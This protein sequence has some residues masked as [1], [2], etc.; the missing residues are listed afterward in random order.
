MTQNELTS[1]VSSPLGS[2]SSDFSRPS[3]FTEFVAEDTLDLRDDPLLEGLLEGMLSASV[4]STR[5]SLS[6]F[7]SIIVGMVGMSLSR[8]ETIDSRGSDESV[9]S[10]SAMVCQM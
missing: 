6:I 5:I 8:I 10:R 3:Q 7:W 9:G 2:C 4:V 1:S